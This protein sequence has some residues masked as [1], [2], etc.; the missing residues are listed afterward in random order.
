MPGLPDLI[1]KAPVFARMEAMSRDED[2]WKSQSSKDMLNQI[3]L[4]LGGT[5]KSIVDIARDMGLYDTDSTKHFEEHWLNVNGNGYWR[6][7]QSQV[8]A[9]L[10]GGMKRAC[11]LFIANNYAKPFEYFWV[12]SGDTNSSRWEMSISE[13][14]NQVTVMFH[15]PQTPPIYSK[16]ILNPKMTLV[17]FD[18]T[19]YFFDP[20]KI[21]IP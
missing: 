17:K 5:S 20:V 16:W 13:G 21:P 11:E 7:M 15:T 10:R 4:D 3:V 8:N 1:L 19:N 14:E 9:V 6:N 2:L 18:G 12:I